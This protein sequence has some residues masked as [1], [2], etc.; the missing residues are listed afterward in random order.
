MTGNKILVIEDNPLNLEL[1][2][3]LLEAVGFNVGQAH[4]AEEG[5]H[6]ALKLRPDLIFMDLS[7]PGIDGLTATKALRAEPATCNLIIVALTA[8]AMKG[9]AEL[10]L[11]A[12]CD[13]YL[14]KPIDTRTFAAKAAAFIRAGHTR[15]SDHPL[16]PIYENCN[17]DS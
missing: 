7:L 10:A 2:T 3:D 6:L 16:T 17:S 4:T 11:T 1:V 9:D 15:S 14:A 12:G 13:G 5:L 8:H